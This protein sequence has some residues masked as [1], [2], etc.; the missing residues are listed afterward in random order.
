MMESIIIIVDAFFVIKIIIFIFE[1]HM[2]F[3]P[4]ATCIWFN[5]KKKSSRDKYVA[6]HNAGER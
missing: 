6:K 2:F 1:W 3:F 5:K 4:S